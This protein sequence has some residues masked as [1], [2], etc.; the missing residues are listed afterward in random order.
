MVFYVLD[1]KLLGNVP[2]QIVS[3]LVWQTCVQCEAEAMAPLR[4]SL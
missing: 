2:V 3:S 4:G 1:I